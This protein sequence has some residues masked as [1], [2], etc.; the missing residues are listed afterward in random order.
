MKAA[1]TVPRRG[2]PGDRR[3]LFDKIRWRRSYR[4][5][6]FS[7]SDYLADA[8]EGIMRSLA[9]TVY[10]KIRGLE[11]SDYRQDVCDWLTSAEFR[12]AKQPMY[13]NRCRGLSLS[14]KGRSRD[15]R[16]S[17]GRLVDLGLV[18][19]DPEVYLG[20]GPLSV[21]SRYA[22]AS[23]VLMKVVNI[24]QTL[25]SEDVPEEVLDYCVYAHLT[26]IGMG[27]G[28]MDQTRRECI[29]NDELNRFP[30]RAHAVYDM[31]RLGIRI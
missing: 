15:L 2:P 30:G 3:T 5:I 10:S 31:E 27:F 26:H 25:D 9:D 1:R 28:N 24:S 11:E 13:I 22:G 6:E 21:S 29:F 16:D 14:T 4:W 17:Y 12:R 23:S 18:E 19:H 20:W 8:P 7:V